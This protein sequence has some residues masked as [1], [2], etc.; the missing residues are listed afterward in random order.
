MDYTIEQIN[1][2][3]TKLTV[4]FSDEG[5]NLQGE[6]NVKGSKEDAEKYVDAFA[7]DLKQN[8]IELFP[9]PPE[10]DYPEEEMV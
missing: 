1:E 7:K 4:D 6:T 10:P 8:N 3:T 2:K 9:E 5:I